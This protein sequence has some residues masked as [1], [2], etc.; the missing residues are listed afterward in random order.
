MNCHLQI[1]ANGQWQD[2]AAL[3]VHRPELGGTG[4]CTFEY[5]LDYVFGE[6]PAPVSMR[7]PVEARLH[8]QPHWPSFLF[9]LIPQGTGRKYLL[10]EL[11][12]PDD[13]TADL[14]LIGAG[15]FNPIGRIRVREAVDYFHR[16]VGRHNTPTF[17]AGM[18]LDQLLARDQ[19]FAERMLIHGMLAAGTTGVQGAAPKFLLTRDHQGRWHG[20]G[21]LA[22]EQAAQHFIVKLPR[23][24]DA[25]DRKVLRN[26]AAYIRTAAKMGLRVHGET[27]HRNDMLF[28]PRFDRVIDGGRVIRLHQESAAS[29]AGVLGFDARPSQF[30][31]LHALRAVVTHRETET[32]EF[33]KRDV[34]NLAM[35]NTDNHARNTAIQLVD[36]EVRLTPLFDFGPMYLDPELIARVC[37]WYHPR[38]RKEL[39][40]WGDVIDAIDLGAGERAR[41]RAGMAAFG[42]ALERLDDTMRWAGVE[43]DIIEHLQAGI[44]EQARQL[45][46][47][48]R[49]PKPRRS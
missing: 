7:Y 5:E 8:L 29:V 33:L 39:T 40:V 6:A 46:D 11:N 18:T 23:G 24:K 15:A 45:R 32:V 31:L 27:E 13:R 16:H 1:Y 34:L 47:L 17:A 3:Q 42:A 49:A 25:A 43:D 35:R 41:I 28:I 10:G 30:D 19:E 20:D 37:R 26:E 12:L 22:D 2:A 36:C 48:A 21:A 14:A 44:E 9:D 38:T 4:A